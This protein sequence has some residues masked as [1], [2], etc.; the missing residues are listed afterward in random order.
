MRSETLKE[1]HKQLFSSFL[2]KYYFK[3][4]EILVILFISEWFHFN[5]QVEARVETR[6]AS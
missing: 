5:F 6:L 2:E 3:V 4:D 1:E